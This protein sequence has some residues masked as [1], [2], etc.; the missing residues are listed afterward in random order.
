MER[1]KKAGKNFRLF[2]NTIYIYIEREYIISGEKKDE[3][4]RV[5]VEDEILLFSFYHLFNK[6]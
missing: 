2:K 4:R 6:I 5:E 3:N 1:E